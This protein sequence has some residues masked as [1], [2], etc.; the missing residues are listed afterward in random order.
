MYVD[1]CSFACIQT[2][3]MLID[4]HG[5]STVMKDRYG[6]RPL[7]ILWLDRRFVGTCSAT[8]IREELIFTKRQQMLITLTEELRRVEDVLTAKRRTEILLRARDLTENFVPYLWNVTRESS[9]LRTEHKKYEEYI[10]PDTQSLFYAK[11]PVNPIRGDLH[12]EWT[13]FVPSPPG[14][15]LEAFTFHFV[16]LSSYCCNT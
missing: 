9:I 10:D 11:Q 4:V 1:L 6:S 2:I 12:T 13:W 3:V 5:A 7:D 16:V 15:S 14:T 8:Q